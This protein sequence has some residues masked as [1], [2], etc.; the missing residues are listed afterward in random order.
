V[1]LVTLEQC[2]AGLLALPGALAVRVPGVLSKE[3]SDAFV[4]GVYAG[5]A[6]WTPAFDGE[7]FSLG[8]AWY[9]HL[10]ED[11]EAEY[12]ATRE[13]SD[14]AVEQFCPGLAAMMRGLLGAFVGEP[15]VPRRGFAGPGVHVFP[16][17]AHC[18]MRGGAVHFD[19]EGLTDSELAER[20]PAVTAVLMMQLPRAGGEL[21]VWDSLYQGED[22]EDEAPRGVPFLDVDYAVGEIVFIDSYR[23]HQIRPFGG[24]VDRVSATV[25]SVRNAGGWSAWF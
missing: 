21:R 22:H 15:V 12:F 17:G 20:A 14:A 3:A 7:Q 8:N 23:L 11:K 10:E 24:A 9:T 16:A 6:H 2:N 1:K 13:R 18:A 4:R 25:H 5:R 19:T